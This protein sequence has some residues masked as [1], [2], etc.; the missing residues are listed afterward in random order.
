VNA[1]KSLYSWEIVEE[2]CAR[3]IS[4]RSLVDICRDPGLPARSTVYA[5]LAARP[6]F[7]GKYARACLMRLDAHMEEDIDLE[8]QALDGDLDPR[9]LQVVTGNRRWRAERLNPGKYGAN[10]K[11]NL[12]VDIDLAR[13]IRE[14]RARATGGKA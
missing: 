9:V 7:A 12:K 2:I 11:I 1:G 13:R 5:W 4:G 6:E 14:G 3:I 8:R 10:Q